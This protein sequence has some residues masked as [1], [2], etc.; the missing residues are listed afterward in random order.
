[1]SFPGQ[2]TRSDIIVFCHITYARITIV[3][4]CVVNGELQPYA[5]RKTIVY[6][7]Y[8]RSP[9]TASVLLHISPSTIVLLYIQS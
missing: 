2:T 3:Y 7:P 6:K 5:E 8:V 4:F 9:H 1:M